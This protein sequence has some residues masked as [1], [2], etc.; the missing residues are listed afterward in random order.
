MQEAA[1]GSY[2]HPLTVGGVTIPCNLILGPMAGTTD[3][4][5]RQLCRE[6]GAGLVCGEM[7]S[8]KAVIYK[9]KNTQALCRTIPAEHPVSLQLFGSDPAVMAEAAAMIEELYDY[10]LLDINMGCPVDKIVNNGEGSALMKDP[11]RIEQIVD[12]VVRATARPV[13]VKLRKGYYDTDNTALVCAQA[14]EAGGAS[15]VTVHGRTRQQFYRGKA[16]WRVIAQVRD[17]LR[18]PVIGSGDVTDGPSCLSMFR[19]T[20]CDG[21][22]IARAAQ[23]NPWVFAEVI[24]FLESGTI[25]GHPDRQAVIDMLLRHARLLVEDKGEYIG[26]REMRRHAAW[27]LKGIPGAAK[28]RTRMTALEHYEELEELCRNL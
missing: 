25:P 14:A 15:M 4:S 28:L 22:M 13:T 26:M 24:A 6:Q 8:A 2:L 1:N 10:E 7:V 3:V 11:R 20:G 9:N 5:F 12:A 18:I 16:D 17:G 19:E 23:G 27:Y 21:V